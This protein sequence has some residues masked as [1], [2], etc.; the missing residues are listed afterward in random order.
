M[1]TLNQV[2]FIGRL[3]KNPE[4]DYVGQTGDLARTRVSL[5]VDRPHK[6]D[7]T[8]W[9]NLVA[10]K[11]SAEFLN[12]YGTKGRQVYIEGHLQTREWEDGEHDTNLA[13]AQTECV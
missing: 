10:F 6:K 3:G 4:M 12:Q 2:Q 11:Q 13:F 7:A 5:A 8:D 9:V 1:A